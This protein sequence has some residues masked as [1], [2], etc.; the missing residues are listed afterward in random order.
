MPRY[1][2]PG[3]GGQVLKTKAYR[4]QPCAMFPLVFGSRPVIQGSVVV[5][6]YVAPV[7]AVTVSPCR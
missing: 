2:A 4:T 7:A 3:A 6:R 1:V 5:P